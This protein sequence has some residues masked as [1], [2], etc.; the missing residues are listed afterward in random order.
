MW[1]GAGDA[2]HDSENPQTVKH[3]RRSATGYPQQKISARVH[4]WHK[5]AMDPFRGKAGRRWCDNCPRSSRMQ[6]APGSRFV[7]TML[8]VIETCRQQRRYVFAFITAARE[9]RITSVIRTQPPCRADLKGTRRNILS[10]R[11]GD[12]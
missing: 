3:Q 5:V 1:G 11:D 2:I 7:E 12:K 9:S 6:S 10:M 4:A 8:T